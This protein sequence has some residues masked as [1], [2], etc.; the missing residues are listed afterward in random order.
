MNTPVACGQLGFR[1][2]GAAC[3]GS[4]FIGHSYKCA[5]MVQGSWAIC[6]PTP[7]PPWLQAAH[8]SQF[9]AKSSLPICDQAFPSSQKT[10]SGRDSSS[11]HHGQ[12]MAAGGLRG[13]PCKGAAQ[14]EAV[15]ALTSAFTSSAN[16]FCGPT[17]F[18]AVKH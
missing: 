3:Q 9:L 16:V 11:P 8:K 10:P 6:P 7:S 17:V 1:S 18:L 13:G 5:S 4:D 14:A 2:A 15:S 12:S